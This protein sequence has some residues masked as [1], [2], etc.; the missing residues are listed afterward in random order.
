MNV[1]MVFMAFVVTV[2]SATVDGFP[3][4][5]MQT[6][7]NQIA[8]M[9]VVVAIAVMITAILIIKVCKLCATTRSQQ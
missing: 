8:G 7:T 1:S 4:N 3:I 9:V 6:P 5:S 2:F